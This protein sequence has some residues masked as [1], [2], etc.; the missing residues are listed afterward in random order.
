MLKTDVLET[1]RLI[2]RPL[3][4]DDFAAVHAWAGNPVNT[5]YM[6][7]GPNN[8][9]QTREFLAAAQA[10]RDFALVLKETNQVIGSCGVYPDDAHDTGVLGWILHIDHWGRGFGTEAAG[11]LIRYSFEDLQLRRVYAQCVASNIGSCKV[12]EHNGMRCE[13]LHREAFFA[14]VDKV[15]V[16]MAEYA[17]LAHEYCERKVGR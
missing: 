15:W 3:V 2:L 13:A 8:E 16:D 1:K 12:M 17:L 4:E 7:W 11:E 9:E 14:R 6:S 10:G 5:R